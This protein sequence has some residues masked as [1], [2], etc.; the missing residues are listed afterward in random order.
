MKSSTVEKI[1]TLIDTLFSDMSKDFLGFN[2]KTKKISSKTKNLVTMFMAGLGKKDLNEIEKQI[3]KTSLEITFNYMDTIRSQTK[4]R[5]LDKVNAYME[6]QKVKGDSVRIIKV[7]EILGQELDRAGKRMLLSVNTEA[8]KIRNL[9]TAMKIE[10]MANQRGIEDPNVFWLV[11]LDEATA[12][13]PEKTLH[14]IPGTT[15]PRVWKLSELSHSYWRKGME[16]PSIYG[17]HPHCFLGHSGI[18]IFTE[19]DG[20]KNIKDVKIGER[21]LTHTGKFKRVLSNLEWY[22]K[23]YYGEYYRIKFTTIG[24]DGKKQHTIK[25]TPEHE[26][27]TDKGWVKAKDLTTNHSLKELFVSC[28]SCGKPVQ[29]KPKRVDS[30]QNK[31]LDSYFCSHKCS[32]TYQSRVSSN[33]LG[34]YHYENLKIDEIKYFKNGKNG[35]KLYDLKVED[36]ESFVINGA[37][38]HNCRCIL[39]FIAPGWGFDSKGKIKYK[40]KK[41]DEYEHQKK[42]L[43]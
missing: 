28:G 6:E 38:S 39:N 40:G 24:R 7:R 12:D 26:F 18:K 20:Y 41:H 37:V 21:V 30:R 8:N 36:D 22:K 13:K 43:K 35:F 4:A 1:T 19:K 31:N 5:V 27:L 17:G 3:L 15:I 29:P 42:M 10:R 9:S 14:L 33:S 32:S 25:V 16:V 34:K 23:K 2:P 11:T